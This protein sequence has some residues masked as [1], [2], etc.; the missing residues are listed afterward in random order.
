MNC[1]KIERSLHAQSQYIIVDTIEEWKGRQL[2]FHTSSGV[3]IFSCTCLPYLCLCC[4][5]DFQ[6]G[7]FQCHF[8]ECQNEKVELPEPGE[9]V[10]LYRWPVPI[11]STKFSL[12]FWHFNAAS[13]NDLYPVI[14]LHNCGGKSVCFS[15][16]L[17]IFEANIQTVTPFLK[18]TFL[19]LNGLV[20]V[21][22]PLELT[23][24]LYFTGSQVLLHLSMHVVSS[25]VASLLKQAISYR[26]IE[27]CGFT[28]TM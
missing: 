19:V 18:C 28:V 21:D 5:M 22:A 15:S 4:G 1:R 25:S 16:H 13:M 26:G 8:Q 24:Q 10:Q 7:S 17:T 12:I 23:N 3:G 14:L 2:L 27:R 6:F 9:T 11:F 20:C